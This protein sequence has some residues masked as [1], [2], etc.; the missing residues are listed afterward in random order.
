MSG[1]GELASP[2]RHRR[3]GHYCKVAGSTI[4]AGGE[5][6]GAAASGWRGEHVEEVVNL[7]GVVNPHHGIAFGALD[8]VESLIIR[9]NRVLPVDTAQPPQLTRGTQHTRQVTEKK[10][11]EKRTLRKAC[12]GWFWGLARVVS[13][14]V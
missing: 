13:R 9:G 8:G 7:L 14:E 10:A 6:P 2:R 4:G 12:G 5:H 11:A 3:C 1:R